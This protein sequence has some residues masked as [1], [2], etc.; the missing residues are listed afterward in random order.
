MNCSVGAPTTAT[1]PETATECPNQSA[2]KP[3][4]SWN[5]AVSHCAT[6]GPAGASS[7]HPNRTIPLVLKASTMRRRRTFHSPGARAT[8]LERLATGSR[9]PCT[10]MIIGFVNGESGKNYDH[11]R[12]VPW[13]AERSRT[14]AGNRQ[15]EGRIGS[16]L[17][18]WYARENPT[19]PASDR[20]SAK[21]WATPCPARRRRRR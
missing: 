16:R 8:T 12:V 4:G 21:P 15:W 1:F 17:G 19:S 9:P 3:P 11:V 20:A 6:A 18:L 13:H 5:S 10:R 7:T 2:A 14:G